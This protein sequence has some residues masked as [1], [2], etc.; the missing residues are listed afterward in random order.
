M[1]AATEVTAL[2]IDAMRKIVSFFIGTFFSTS[3]RPI[4][5]NTAIFPARAM[6]TVAPAMWCLLT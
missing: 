3:I 6:T 1:A 2:L 4:G 5:S